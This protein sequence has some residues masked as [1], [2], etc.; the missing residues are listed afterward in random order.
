[1]YVLVAAF[2]TIA[3]RRKQP[4][5]LS[6]DEWI[7]KM[8]YVHTVKYYSAINRKEILTYTTMKLE[9]IVLSEISH[10]TKGKNTIWFHLYEVPVCYA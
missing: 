10:H 6:T 8:W 5:C 4:Q 2:F 3:K 1:M 7:N 9:D